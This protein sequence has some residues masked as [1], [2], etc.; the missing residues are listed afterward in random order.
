VDADVSTL[1][2]RDAFLKMLLGALFS[3]PV[4]LLVRIVLR[5]ALIEDRPGGRR[6]VAPRA[7]DSRGQV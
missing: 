5:A 2:I 3:L 6:P 1:V 4:F 7:A